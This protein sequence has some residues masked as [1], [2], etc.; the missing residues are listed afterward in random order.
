MVRDHS[1][2]EGGVEWTH[3]ALTESAPSLLD[4]QA[5]NVTV[6]ATVGGVAQ[7]VTLTGGAY[8]TARGCPGNTYIFGNRLGSFKSPRNKPTVHDCEVGKSVHA[9]KSSFCFPSIMY[10][11]GT[12]VGK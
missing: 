5:A 3:C 12:K 1:S 2:R 7:T 4:G 8:N 10:P 11:Y 9:T 6:T